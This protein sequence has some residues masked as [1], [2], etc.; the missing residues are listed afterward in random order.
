M[1][2]VFERGGAKPMSQGGG[3]LPQ[4]PKAILSEVTPGKLEAL[5][6]ILLCLQTRAQPCTR[7]SRLCQLE[8]A[9]AHLDGLS[10]SDPT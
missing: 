5:R 4:R 6:Y 8:K 7:M 2:P 3:G 1:A 9:A 10:A